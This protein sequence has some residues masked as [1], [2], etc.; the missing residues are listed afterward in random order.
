M[1]ASV[2]DCVYGIDIGGTKVLGV[3][4]DA[5]SEVVAETRTA[6]NVAAGGV[7]AAIAFV[8][9]DLTRQ[10]GPAAAIG[11]GIAGLVDGEG[12]MRFGPNLPDVLALP[13]R[14]QMEAA[15]GVPVC[16][17]NDANCA[18]YGELKMGALRGA[19]NALLVTLGTGIGGAIIV[20]GDIY[21]GANGFAAE[22]GHFTVR[23]EG[24]VCAC[25]EVGHWEAIACGN[26]LGRMGSEAIS[27][28]QGGAITAANSSE[29][30]GQDVAAAAAAGDPFAIAVIAAFADNVALGL[31]G[32]ANILDPEVIV[33]AGGLVEM[34]PL[35]F[36]PVN[37]AFTRHLEGLAHRPHIPV[38]P[39]ILGERAGAIGA[40]LQASQLRAS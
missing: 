35:L 23:Q 37:L 4:V 2:S 11:V 39:A 20:H 30:T 3:A 12:S 28:G 38:R 13:V 22:I 33:I 17:D 6:S 25:G 31:A 10:C 5:A 15:T 14:Q 19:R 34:G 40:A 18:G 36:D 26:A 32:L 16:V 9:G 1:S 7:E 21:R 24:P 29:V 27:V 8:L